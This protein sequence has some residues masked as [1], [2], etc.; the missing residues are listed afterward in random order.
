MITFSGNSRID[1]KKIWKCDKAEEME[2][3][4]KSDEFKVIQYLRNK[5]LERIF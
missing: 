4:K 1:S 3:V 5:K 2:E